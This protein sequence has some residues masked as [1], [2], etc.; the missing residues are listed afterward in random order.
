MSEHPMLKCAKLLESDPPLG[1]AFDKYAGDIFYHLQ[2]SR[3]LK[4]ENEAAD[5]EKKDK[6][7]TELLD[8]IEQ[9]GIGRRL[10]SK[11]LIERHSVSDDDAEKFLVTFE[12]YCKQVDALCTLLAP[13]L[14]GDL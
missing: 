1:K 3:L 7:V 9:N 12:S 14:S 11:L 2:L 10:L 8:L 4:R 6:V 5:Y 13:G